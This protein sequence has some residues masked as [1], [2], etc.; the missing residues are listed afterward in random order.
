MPQGDGLLIVGQPVGQVTRPE[1]ESAAE[2]RGQ[3]PVHVALAGDRKSVVE[4]SRYGK[5][6]PVPREVRQFRPFAQRQPVQP[7]FFRQRLHRQVEAG[8]DREVVL[9]HRI[10]GQS[11]AEHLLDVLLHLLF[12]HGLHA[13]QEFVQPRVPHLRAELRGKVERVGVHVDE[14]RGVVADEAELGR[15]QPAEG[16]GHQHGVQQRLVRV[17]LTRH[18]VDQFEGAAELAQVRGEHVRAHQRARRHLLR[19]RSFRRGPEHQRAVPELAE[20][21]GQSSV[22]HRRL[23]H[24]R[25][26]HV[27]R[28]QRVHRRS[29]AGFVHHVAVVYQHLEFAGGGLFAHPAL[30]FP[31]PNGVETGA[32]PAEE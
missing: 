26:V 10:H 1:V 16:V 28:A 3:R 5:I 18:A 15:A 6:D 17:H 23:H 13:V 32:F 24:H 14:A 27:R 31:S 25:H 19:V 2:E 20:T 7:L 12:R 8:I 21:R 29:Q 9:A 30:D 22:A 11:H 4:Q